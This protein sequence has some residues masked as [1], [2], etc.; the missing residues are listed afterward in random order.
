[1]FQF[2]RLNS[3]GRNLLETHGLC[4]LPLPLSGAEGS[5]PSQVRS[6]FCVRK[7]GGGCYDQVSSPSHFFNRL[8]QR[9]ASLRS[10]SDKGRRAH[11]HTFG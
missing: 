11:I 5:K 3:T 1:M 6:K 8:L 9:G 10:A 7:G 4:R 2:W